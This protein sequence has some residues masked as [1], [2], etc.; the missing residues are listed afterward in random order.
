MTNAE[1]KQF[2]NDNQDFREYVDRSCR[3]GRCTVEQALTHKITATVAEEYQN[4][5]GKVIIKES[6]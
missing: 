6:E 1:L 2:Y 3:T 4:K 5:P